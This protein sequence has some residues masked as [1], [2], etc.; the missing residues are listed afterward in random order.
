MFFFLFL[1]LVSLKREIEKKKKHIK[2]KNKRAKAKHRSS[3]TLKVEILVG[4]LSNPSLQ[5]DDPPVLFS[6][7]AQ[8]LG[9]PLE[10]LE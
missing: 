6:R 5:G 8:F 2:Q 1:E 3:L 7:S 9:V 4:N 10:R